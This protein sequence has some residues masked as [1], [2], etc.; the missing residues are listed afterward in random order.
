MI[1]KVI[2]TRQDATPHVRFGNVSIHKYQDNL[3][4][5]PYVAKKLWQDDVE[6][7]SF[8]QN[9]LLY[10]GLELVTRPV[11]VGLQVAYGAVLKVRTRRGGEKI[12][13]RGQTKLLKNLFQEWKIPPWQ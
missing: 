13:L 1:Y 2:F 6:W 4:I 5:I 7:K 10:D 12:R 9:L 11:D 8:P 3:Y